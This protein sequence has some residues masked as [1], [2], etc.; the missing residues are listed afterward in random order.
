[1]DGIVEIRMGEVSEFL[2][3]W[4]EGDISWSPEAAMP[5]LGQFKDAFAM[6]SGGVYVLLKGIII[7]YVGQAVCFAVRIGQHRT[8]KKIKFDGAKIFPCAHKG[9]RLAIERMLIKKYNPKWNKKH[10]VEP[11]PVNLVPLSQL[12]KLAKP[13]EPPMRRF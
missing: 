5:E 11:R 13:V 7:V 4:D 10:K 6:L 2:D 12:M 3:C 8:E 9:R 1:M